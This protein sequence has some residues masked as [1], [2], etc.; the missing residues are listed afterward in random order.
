MAQPPACVNLF[1]QHI[2][3][4]YKSSQVLMNKRLAIFSFIC[5]SVHDNAHRNERKQTQTSFKKNKLWCHA[6]AAGMRL[7]SSATNVLAEITTQLSAEMCLSLKVH[8]REHPWRWIMWTVCTPG[9]DQLA[10][11]RGT[12]SPR[13]VVPPF[14]PVRGRKLQQL[15]CWNSN[16]T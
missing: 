4:I 15:M 5:R 1:M 14:R 12:W 13:I 3:I 2:Y 11:I 10:K 16:S 6:H 8:D 9:I 7:E